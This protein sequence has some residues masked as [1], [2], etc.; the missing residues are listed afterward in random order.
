MSSAPQR[1]M[2]GDGLRDEDLGVF[3]REQLLT[4]GR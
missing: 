4:I 3:H 2:Y 1:P